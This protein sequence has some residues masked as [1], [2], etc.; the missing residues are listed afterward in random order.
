MTAFQNET[1]ELNA[2]LR[3]G[4]DFMQRL[5][6]SRVDAGEIAGYAIRM[7]KDGPVCDMINKICSE[8]TVLPNFLAGQRLSR[9]FSRNGFD[10][11]ADMF[12]SEDKM[13][14]SF[15]WEVDGDLS[16]EIAEIVTHVGT[17]KEAF[18]TNDRF[19]ALQRSEKAVR[20]VVGLRSEIY[21][22][23]GVNRLPAICGDGR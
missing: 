16:N 22:R 1:P 18:D 10:E 12:S 20:A 8:E 7:T 2:A 4:I 23:F 6:F 5:G 3:R 14:V 21:H 17:G 19:A 9:W 15:H 13:A 11:V